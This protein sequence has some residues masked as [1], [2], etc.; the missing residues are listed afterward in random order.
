L[1]PF[2]FTALEIN[3]IQNTEYSFARGSGIVDFLD[4]GG[5]GFGSTEFIVLRGK[6]E[7]RAPY[8]A[9]LSKLTSFRDHCIQNMV[10]SS[11]RQRV[12]NSCFSNYFLALPSRAELLTAF[13]SL[14][15]G[16]F[17]KVTKNAEQ[18]RTLTLLRDTLLPKLI[19]GEIRI[20]DA[21]KLAESAA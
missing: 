18:I 12:Q 1:K 5:V 15:K 20:P 7:I 6:N 3:Y 16:N 11:G 9:C 19:S 14:T 2:F 8:V 10:G 13:D 4:E 17:D 21:E